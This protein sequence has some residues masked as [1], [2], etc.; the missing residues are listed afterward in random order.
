MR[1]KFKKRIVY[2]EKSIKIF[3]LILA[4]NYR[5]AIPRQIY[6]VMIDFLDELSTDPSLQC[7]STRL[8]KDDFLDELNKL[9]CRS[10]TRLK[11]AIKISHIITKF[12]HLV[13]CMPS[14]LF[15]V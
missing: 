13:I 1:N 9:L 12:D 10:A 5:A 6:I 3:I 15:S 11:L 7:I 4:I 14:F 2:I 8:K